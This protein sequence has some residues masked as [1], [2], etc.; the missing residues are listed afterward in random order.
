MPLKL[1]I[2]SVAGLAGLLSVTSACQA[3]PALPRNDPDQGV[4]VLEDHF[5]RS[6]SQEL[7]D[8][9]GNGWS[10]NEGL[11]NGRKQFDLQN[12]LVKVTRHKE[13][14]HGPSMRWQID[15]VDANGNR[16]DSVKDAVARIRFKVRNG[17]FSFS[18]GDRTEKSVRHNNIAAV[19]VMAGRVELEDMKLGGSDW[20]NFNAVEAGAVTPDIQA[21]LDAT[22]I[23][24]PFNFKLNEWYD[25]ELITRGETLSVKINNEYVGSLTSPGI[26][27]EN[28]QLIR[29][30]GSRNYSVDDAYV[31]SLD[32][33]LPPAAQ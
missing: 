26:A 13:A 20:D 33:P 3:G 23:K 7:K 18:W 15:Y 16:R 9:I 25:L 11:A 17:N 2:L 5:E 29:V 21:V 8:E 4:L 28:K 31:Y 32:P 19:R 10:T 1:N 22:L 30:L 27:H 12:G 14:R 6:E 24:I